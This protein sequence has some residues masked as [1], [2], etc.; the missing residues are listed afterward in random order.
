MRGTLALESASEGSM[1]RAGFSVPASERREERA[2]GCAQVN[3]CNVFNGYIRISQAT[4]RP[5][6]VVTSER[7]R[8]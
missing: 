4:S 1:N 2:T 6:A 7:R 5:S 3:V 8:I